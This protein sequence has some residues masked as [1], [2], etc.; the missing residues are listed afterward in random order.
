LFKKIASAHPLDPARVLRL[1]RIASFQRSQV[2]KRAQASE[3]GLTVPA[4]LISSVTRRCNLDCAGCYAKA[5]R[6]RR[7]GAEE[8]SDDR[9]LELFQEAL[10]MGTG[11]LMLA[12]GEPLLRRPLLEKAARIKGP[13]IPYS[14]TAF[15]WTTNIWT[16][17]SGGALAP[18]FSI[19]GD[20]AQTS[21]RRGT[22]VHEK[23]LSAMKALDDRGA[24]FGVS[25]TATSRNASTLLSPE[26]LREL[27]DL[28]VSALFVVE[29]VPAV[30]GTDELVLTDEQKARLA[31]KELFR[32]LPYPVVI[33]PGD[34]ED[35]GGCLA[36]GRGFVHLSPEGALEACPFAPFSDTSAADR[37][38]KEALE[39]PLL[40]ATGRAAR[41]TDG[42][43]GRLRA[44]EQGGL[45]S[46]PGLLRG[47]GFLTVGRPR[48]R[49]ARCGPGAGRM[50][51]PWPGPPRISI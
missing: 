30:P 9:F 21:D 25:V 42:N 15:L 3:R 26:F 14:R 1:S 4:V 8:L 19:E 6:P 24:L 48:D 37:S 22:G 40:A 32:K 13:I 18:V 49:T 47:A 41:R 28:G 38:L 23:V 34:E 31:S 12:G 39:S 20:A 11:V 50:R 29:Y 51:S 2:R 17:S 43:P 36:A 33:L 16:F 27:G 5:L 44:L 10:D 7:E 46:V 35:Y 45:D